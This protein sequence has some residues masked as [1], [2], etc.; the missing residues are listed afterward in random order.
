MRDLLAEIVGWVFSLLVWAF[1]LRLLLQLVRADFRNPLAQAIVKLTNPV[2]IPLRRVL[3]A[4]GRVDT[5]SVLALLAT[6][7]LAVL[8]DRLLLG[9][10]VPAPLPLLV[11][12]VFELVHQALSFYLFAIFV[13]AILGWVVTDGYSPLMRL[14]GDLVEPCM[15]PARRVV[16]RLEGLDLSPLAVCAVLLILARLATLLEGQVLSALR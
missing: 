11:L 5:A 1:L 6:Q 4:L 10:G 16:P 2:V 12:T 15:R 14:L 7:A 8:V 9:V 3:P 13:W